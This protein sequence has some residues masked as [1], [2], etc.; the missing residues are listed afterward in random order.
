MEGSQQGGGDVLTDPALVLLGLPVELERA[1]GLEFSEQG[2]DDLEVDV[3]THVDP[4]D[5]E[6][7]EEGANKDGIKVAENFGSGEEEVANVVRSVHSD[8]NVGEVESVAEPNEG[9]A[10][11]VM[12]DQLLEVLAGL[13]HT[14]KQNNG[15]L[16]PVGSLK[17]VVELDD[18][19]MCAVREGLVH[20][21][22]VK[23]PDG[24]L[25]HDVETS[26][27]E[28]TKVDGRVSL[29]HKSRLLALS[30]PGSARKRSKNFLHDKLASEGQDDGIECDKS[31]VPG[32]FA[33][34][35]RLSILLRDLVGE[36][37][38]VMDRVGLV[39]PDGVCRDEQGENDG[40]QD[41]CV[42]DHH[43]SHATDNTARTTTL[44]HALGGG[45]GGW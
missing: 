3:V 21:G 10:D 45:R 8:A 42:L 19:K 14:Q 15:L 25:A 27:A 23:V 32:A 17:E 1:D 11:N 39:G 40:R 37:D 29:F 26:R 43:M 2:P 44:G 34:L 22:G 13:L 5:H 31:K 24:G 4:H 12:A 33:V 38:E 28:D 35:S 7:E 16:G 30:K 18:T 9:Q 41:V 36:E 20:A 6:D